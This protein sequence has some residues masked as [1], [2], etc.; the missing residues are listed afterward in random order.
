MKIGDGAA[1]LDQVE[2][3]AEVHRL[4]LDLDAELLAPDGD[5]R[6]D[7]QAVAV[8]DDG[9]ELRPVVVAGLVEQLSGARP[10]R[11]PGWG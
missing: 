5:R 2:E 9:A 7:E 3:V 10:G 4:D 11:P 8:H 1:G 6:I